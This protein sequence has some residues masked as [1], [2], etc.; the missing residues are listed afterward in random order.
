MQKLS[1]TV[2]GY[3]SEETPSTRYRYLEMEPLLLAKGITLKFV[4]KKDIVT[5]LVN[6]YSPL[7]Q[8]DAL[9]VQKCLF[10]KKIARKIYQLPQPIF[11]DLD[12][13]IWTR[14][15]KPYNFFT[16]FKVKSRLHYALKNAT[17]TIVANSFLY[18]YVSPYAKKIYQVNMSLKNID[19]I[20]KTPPFGN[21]KWAIGWLGSPRNLSYL[22]Q[23]EKPLGIFLEAHPSVS[24]KVYCGKAPEWGIPHS[25]IPYTPDG[26]AAFLDSINVGL[27]PLPDEIYSRGK[28]PIKAIHYIA[29][30][31]PVIANIYGATADILNRQNAISVDSDQSIVDAL[32]RLKNEPD[33]ATQL[34][35]SGQSHFQQHYT[36]TRVANQLTQIISTHL[37]PF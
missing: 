35:R 2:I 17:A 11:F 29:S 33:L 24:L 26:E 20:K 5:H 14:P 37:P 15:E 21:Q 7:Y 25:H 30:G 18:Q 10:C 1:I 6:L 34:G 4:Y 3:G 19:R 27:L 9:I 12:D 23:W 36:A 22:Y 32:K 13:A 28:S 8:C 16:R 31:I